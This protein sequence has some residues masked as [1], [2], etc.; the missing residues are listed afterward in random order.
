M[1]T[2]S[3]FYGRACI[4]PGSYAATVYNPTS[5]V[6]VANFGNVMIIDT[7]LS[8]NNEYEFAG[9]AGING[10]L[11]KGLKSVYEF[12]DYES[13]AAF[14]GGGKVCDIAQKLFTP[15]GQ[16]K[17]T[18]KLYY[19]RAA[20]TKCANISLEL[21]AGITLNL[22]C[23]NE[24]I[25]GN[26]AL[27]GGVLKVGYAA[28]IIAG[29]NGGF[30]LQVSRGSFQGVDEAGESYGA[31]SVE[32]AEPSLL[33][34]SE[35][36]ETLAQL[37]NWAI[38]DKTILANFIVSKAG[39]E[40]TPLKVVAQ[41]LAT[42]G[43]SGFLSNGDFDAVLEAIPELDVTFFL[44]TKYGAEG[45]DAATNGKLY[46]FLKNSAKFD[47]FMVVPGGKDDSDLLGEV[48]TSQ[49][50]AKLYNSG[51][52]VVIH[53]AP[54]VVRKD[55]NGTKQLDSIY[56]AADVIGLA[57]GAAPQTPLTFKRVGYQSFV[58]D[59]KK[60]E[61]EKALQ[62]GIMHARNVSGYWCI[63]Q[64]ITSLQDNKKAISD[65]GQSMEL[66]IELIK[67]QLN[68]ELM[69]EGATRFTG[70][71]AAQS[72][73]ASVKNFTETKLSSLV[74]KAGADNLIISWK[75]A[76]VVALNGDYTITYDFVPNV[77]VNKTFFVG[78]M[79]DFKV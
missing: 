60:K 63:N 79:L 43:T 67:A 48:G 39:L 50:I 76:K 20:T 27:V 22:K 24:G 15:V 74:A 17:G 37:Y 11:S 40:T 18:P 54:E 71:T 64:G 55:G 49:A 41:V 77:P 28:K 51:K 10:E 6:N 21:S 68:K 30:A 7:G 13:F 19:T 45:T 69:L 25:A 3:N 35:E 1:S 36:F 73:P 56:F 53:G 29:I 57:A 52:V 9:G 75:N 34:E 66:S 46:T 31:K 32:N 44:C 12:S 58:Y 16:S 59:L 47:E 26:G 4:E 72:N 62:A 33:V 5:V 70:N 61:R 2:V 78:N 14:M 23:K 8:K 42:G 65:D 38:A